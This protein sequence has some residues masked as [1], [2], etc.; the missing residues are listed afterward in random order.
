MAEASSGFSAKLDRY[1]GSDPSIYKRWRRRATIM[2]MSLPNTYPPEKHGAKLMEYLTGD[3]EQACEYI[4]LDELGKEGGEKLVLKALDERYKPLEK[5]DLAEALR[6]YFYEVSVKN[7]EQLKNFVTRLTTA[8]RKLEQQSV[9]LPSEV[10]GWFLVRKMKLD[11]AQESMLLTATQGSYKYEKVCGAVKAIFANTRGVVKSKEAFTA[12]TGGH[13]AHEDGGLV[14]DEEGHMQAALEAAAEEA[15]E[16][17]EYADEEVLEVYE[18]YQQI[19]RRVQETK[20]SR[21]FKLTSASGSSGNPTWNLRGSISA[22]I[23]QAKAR[24]KCHFCRQVGHWK[25]ECPKRKQNVSANGSASKGNKE[26]MIVDEE[27]YDDG[28]IEQLYGEL[29]DADGSEGHDALMAEEVRQ[30]SDHDDDR[31][32]SEMYDRALGHSNRDFPAEFCDLEE[33][34]SHNAVSSRIFHDTH[35]ADEESDSQGSEQYMAPLDS[36]GVPDTACRRSL[37]GE[38]VL[39]KLEDRVRQ[40][41]DRVVRKPCVS[42]FKFGNSG[43]LT[44][45][46]VARIPCRIGHRRVVLQVAVLPHPGS[47]TPFLMSKEMLKALGTR[48]DLEHDVAHFEKLGVTIKLRE[49]SKGHYAVPLFEGVVDRMR[50]RSKTKE[51]MMNSTVAALPSSSARK[52]DHVQHG[53]QPDDTISSE[54]RDS[55][56]DGRHG[57]ME[58]VAV[59][60]DPQAG[61]AAGSTTRL[62]SSCDGSWSHDHEAREVH[63]DEHDFEQHLRDG[64]AVSS[65][66][67]I[68]HSCEF[69][70]RHEDPQRIHRDERCEEGST[71]GGTRIKGN[72]RCWEPAKSS[73][74]STNHDDGATDDYVQLDKGNAEFVR[75]SSAAGAIRDDSNEPADSPSMGNIRGG[76]ANS[77]HLLHTTGSAS[78]E[79]R[80]SRRHGGGLTH[81]CG[82]ASGSSGELDDV[83]NG[84]NAPGARE[85]HV[86]HGPCEDDDSGESGAG[87]EVD[88]QHDAGQAN[89]SQHQLDH[90]REGNGSISDE[91]CWSDAYSRGQKRSMNRR[92]RRTLMQNV[93]NLL[94]H[95]QTGQDAPRIQTE[96]KEMIEVL[97]HEWKW[98]DRIHGEGLHDVSEVFSIPRIAERAKKFGLFPGNSYDLVLGDDLL[99]REH[100]E[101]VLQEIKRDKPFCVVVSPPCTMFSQRR[102]THD[103]EHDIH[104]LKKAVALL[105]FAVQV[106]KLQM[107]GSRYFILEQPQGASSWNVKELRNLVNHGNVHCIDLDMCSYGLKDYA[108]GELHRKATK[109]ATNMD[110]DVCCLLG[111]RCKGDH[112]HQVLEGKVKHH[113]YGWVNRTRL[114]QVYTPEFCDA[115][116]KCIQKQKRRV[117]C[118]TGESHEVFVHEGL[119][120]EDGSKKMVSLIRKVHNNLGHPSNERLCLVLKAAGASQKA[121]EIAKGLHCDACASRSKPPL[122]KVAKVKRTYDFNVGI[123]CDTFE[124]EIGNQKLSCL[125]VICEG[126]NYHLAFPL[127]NNKTALETRRAY[128][129][130]WKAVFG[131][132]IRCFSDGGPEFEKEFHEGLMLDGTMDERSAA[133][134]P[135]QNGLCERHGQ[136]WKHMFS[137]C[138]E[139][140]TPQSRDEIEEIV[141]QVCVAKN[142]LVRKDGFSPSQ[143][144]FGKD[145][146]IPGL[147]YSGD[148]HVGINSAMLAGDSSFCRAMEIRQSARRAFIEADNDERVRRSIEHRTRPERGPFPPGAKVYVWRPG[149]KKRNGNVAMY[150]RGPGTV[151]GSSD[152]CSKFWVS[153]GSK[154]LKCSPE[155]LRRVQPEQEALIQLVPKEV[156]DWNK[157]VS[158]RGVATYHD[159]SGGAV[160]S[161]TADDDDYWTIEGRM[162]KRIHL[163][164]RTSLYVPSSEDN[165]PVDISELQDFRKTLI[166]YRDGQEMTIDDNWKT[167][168]TGVLDGTRKWT[169]QTCFWIVKRERDNGD[170]MGI[171]NGER[172][173]RRRVERD[174]AFGDGPIEQAENNDRNDEESE[175]MES[176]QTPGENDMSVGEPGQDTGGGVDEPIPQ[177]PTVPESELA[178]EMVPGQ[179]GPIRVTPLT[180][181]LRR[182]L[183]TLD[184]GRPRRTG[185]ENEV[186]M[187]VETTSSDQGAEG[188]DG[189]RYVGKGWKIDWKTR[190]VMKLHSARQSKFTPHKAG[191]PIPTSC[192]LGGRVTCARYLDKNKKTEYLVDDY[193]KCKNPHEQLQSQWAGYTAFQFQVPLELEDST[194]TEYEVN[195]VTIKEASRISEVD[196]G[197]TAELDKLLKYQAVEVIPPKEAEKLRSCSVQ[198]KRILPSRFV[199]TRKPDEKTGIMKTKCRWCI[200]GYLD[201]DLTDLQTQS[202]TVSQEAF[203]TTLQTCANNN[204]KIQIADVEGA[205][206]QGD[207]LQREKGE[208]YVELPPDGIPGLQKGTLLHVIKAVYG[209]GDAP[210]HWF[211]K[212]VG[213]LG[214]IGFRQSQ[215]DQCLFH[216]W[217]GQQLH[218]ILCLHVDDMIVAGSESFHEEIIPRLKNSFPFKHWVD[219]QGQFL[220]RT[221]RQCDNGSIEIGQQEFCEKLQPCDI[222]RERRRQKAERITDRETTQLRAITGAINWAVTSSRPDLAVANAVL[223]QRTTRATVHDLVE[224]NK[225]I[226]EAR[227]HSALTLT[228]KPMP[229]DKLALLVPCDAS[230]GTEQDLSSQA[231]YMICMTT[232]DVVNGHSVHVSPLKWKS[233]KQERQVNSTLAAETMAVS[234]GMAEACWMRFFFWR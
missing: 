54:S 128:R 89:Q 234:R 83:D 102:R 47:H 118:G 168:G 174:D 51:V 45:T 132:P 154:V 6:E 153:F 163:Q 194:D 58:R 43:L 32:Q 35:V 115:L 147:L 175:E 124:V 177:P 33:R 59:C 114:A 137:R 169:G 145:V 20:K 86:N 38:A 227:D 73:G 55:E 221:L 87:R 27:F 126:T 176:T 78:K 131:S 178:G 62:A 46:E 66:G 109:L 207:R 49:T 226:G 37:I 21:G 98:K 210:W 1:D 28:E 166:R 215:L 203:M 29:L 113:E 56:A 110:V 116:C 187:A 161:D 99:K 195:E 26:V 172:N 61:R 53:A 65:L 162:L 152:Q 211:Q 191:C 213:V 4:D 219:G 193:K 15:Q 40:L 80:G 75:T 7:G 79:V 39:K 204:W 202:P 13:E 230:W 189:F 52:E 155:Q 50:G 81:K 12:E 71:C 140:E 69:S 129:R 138:V 125:S 72:G 206:L 90:D 208:L 182:D 10:Q 185:N 103:R 121:I 117:L 67:E 92:M 173:V 31:N 11:A 96:K 196:E 198:G 101:R 8:S 156:V 142:S 57:R 122:Q 188:D 119:L 100:R 199:I 68:S 224:A 18:T 91:D 36:H 232:Q 76:R 233:Y 171:D 200:R 2:L 170:N 186:L 34:S 85:V 70:N 225:L 77:R 134:S 190:T 94:E 95:A 127:W 216:W 141:E 149:N 17:N 212:I 205:F 5:D 136:T 218:G 9:K 146:R 183:M 160:P 42:E 48:M 14:E 19:R 44:S 180:Q 144:V 217:K 159:I 164:Q 214:K 130:G 25:R 179:Y 97:L 220:G 106:C 192:L 184:L 150:W 64:Q 60:Q 108:N 157:Q 135:W 24:T 88:G 158:D 228:V 30:Q 41:G 23:E 209:L 93:K 197:K 107:E 133:Y 151:I 22:K 111:K 229:W 222:S 84:S 223:Q 82:E 165:P 201:P 120:D 181:A 16:K 3:A 74:N 148:E 167:D 231:A 112:E 63:E 139:H 104:E 143:R 123:C 105:G